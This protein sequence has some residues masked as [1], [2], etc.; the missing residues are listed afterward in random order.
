MPKRIK[1][2]VNGARMRL[3]ETITE[4][5]MFITLRRRSAQYLLT[6]RFAQMATAHEPTAMSGLLHPSSLC[7]V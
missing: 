6:H 5:L 2:R 7:P 3:Q 1:I 4:F